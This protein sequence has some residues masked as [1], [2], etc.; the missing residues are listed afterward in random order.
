VLDL[1]IIYGPYYNVSVDRRGPHYKGR[2][3]CRQP[4][5]VPKTENMVNF[6]IMP[7][8]P[9]E[10][11]DPDLIRELE[12]LV[13]EYEKRMLVSSDPQ[14]KRR[15]YAVKIQLDECIERARGRAG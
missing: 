12:L 5:D 2:R 14:E 9:D 10:N 7:N 13:R 15:L 4:W 6:P 3:I 1:L 8:T 11:G